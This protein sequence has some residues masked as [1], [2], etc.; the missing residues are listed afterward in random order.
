MEEKRKDM[1]WAVDEDEI[2]YLVRLYDDPGRARKLILDSDVV[3]FGWTEGRIS[4]LEQERLSSGK[5]S[6]RVSERI[7]REGQWKF[8]SP[9]GLAA[10]Y[11][12]HIRYRNMPVYLLCTGA[13]VASDFSLI[14]AYPGKMLKWGYFPEGSTGTGQKSCESGKLQLLW[15]GRLI[16]L[17][18]PEFA[19][20]VAAK[21]KAMGLDFALNIVGEGPLKPMLGDMVEELG[22]SD[23]VTITG[24]KRPA[25][26]REYM[27]NAS[28]FLFTSNYLEGWGV[29]VNEAMQQGCAVVASS[30]AG[31]VP[32]LIKDGENGLVYDGGSYDEF[33]KKVLQLLENRD[34][35]EILG[36]AAAD[37]IN[38]LW[39]A[40]VAAKELLR[41]CREYYEGQSPEPSQQ[42]PMSRAQVIPAP[43]FGRTLSEKN[44]LE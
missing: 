19:V 8:V 13:Y 31:A 11:R 40:D 2:P 26:V 29:V 3:L 28:V 24:G 14:K 12:E 35:I 38:T 27:K 32:F 15:V 43:G 41:F 17:K 33:E 44:H 30:E 37:T 10:K 36:R 16:D 5:L 22:L 1:G 42:G 20:K 7:Y 34:E 4:D 6:F 39:N 25:E 23:V 9:R 21:L 18:H